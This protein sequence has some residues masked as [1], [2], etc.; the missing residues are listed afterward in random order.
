MSEQKLY[1]TSQE[2]MGEIEARTGHKVSRNTFYSWLRT[3]DLRQRRLKH[4][5]FIARSDLDIFLSDFDENKQ[6][7]IEEAA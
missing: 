2:A 6:Q 1:L 5:V 7:L 4:K 3:G